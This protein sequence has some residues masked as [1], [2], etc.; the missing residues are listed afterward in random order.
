LARRSFPAI[1]TTGRLNVF[2][3]PSEAI[4]RVSREGP[5]R[6]ELIKRAPAAGGK[7]GVFA[8]SF[9]PVTIAHVELIRRAAEAFA[10]DET[11]TL[12]GITNA[13]KV[14]YEC[15]LED[16]LAMLSLTLTDE[17]RVSIGVSSHAFYVDMIDALRGEYPLETDLHFIVGFDTFERVLDPEDRYTARYHRHFS[18]RTEALE[19]LFARSSFVVAGRAGAG[20]SSV[21]LLLEREPAVPRD[22]VLYL[23]FP[24]NLGDVS[25]TE[26]RKRRRVGHQIDELVPAAVGQYIREK[27]LYTT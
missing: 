27:G 20:L 17:P 4:D 9:N 1:L 22:R 10:L 3:D 18:S 21:S 19:F 7:V 2:R 12:A 13:D 16:R 6:I 14:E 8:S 25:A 5:P 26:V 15:S 24:E 11:L 23:D